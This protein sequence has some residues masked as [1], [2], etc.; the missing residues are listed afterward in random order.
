MHVKDHGWPLS[1]ADS[2]LARLR[3]SSLD[4]F[5]GASRECL[6]PTLA[7]TQGNHGYRS[8]RG[9]EFCSLWADWVP[10]FMWIWNPNLNAALW[11]LNDNLI[12]VECLDPTDWWT[13]YASS[14]WILGWC[15]LLL[16]NVVPS[17]CYHNLPPQLGN[18]SFLGW[19]G[20]LC[21]W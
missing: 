6:R 2:I 16:E 17:Y 15:T 18:I 4:R 12:W 7:R 14:P 9:W 19:G 5:K 20:G 10:S 8:G 1:Q 11:I 13:E 21:H 3:T